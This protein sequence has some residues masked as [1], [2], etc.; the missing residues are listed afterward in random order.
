MAGF[1]HLLISR[2]HQQD[3]PRTPEHLRQP[4]QGNLCCSRGR[5]DKRT[6]EYHRFLQY[7]QTVLSPMQNPELPLSIPD[8]ARSMVSDPVYILHLHTL[9]YGFRHTEGMRSV[10]YRKRNLL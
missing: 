2:R 6:T 10:H 9:L 3:H 7:R 8:T 1:L 5:A 4:D